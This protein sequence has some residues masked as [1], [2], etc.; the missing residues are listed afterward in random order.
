LVRLMPH[1]RIPGNRSC[2]GV[3]CAAT[4]PALEAAASSLSITCRQPALKLARCLR[5]HV[6]IFAMSGICEPHRR[7]ASPVHICCASALKAKL[8]EAESADMETARAKIMP[9]LRVVLLHREIIFRL[10]SGRSVRPLFL[11][12]TLSRRNDSYR[13]FRH[14]DA[15]CSKLLPMRPPGGSIF[16]R[17]DANG[18][19]T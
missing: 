8:E 18:R 12:Y 10:L 9:T 4:L 16:Q 15:G 13:D 11:G 17:A 1:P 2:K 19:E 6:V 7:N 5:M 3:H 14:T